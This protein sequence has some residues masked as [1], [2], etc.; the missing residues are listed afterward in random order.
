MGGQGG[1][2][3]AEEG[4]DCDTRGPEKMQFGLSHMTILVIVGSLRLWARSLPSAQHTVSPLSLTQ[5]S[6][7]HSII[8]PTLQIRKTE[9]QRRAVTYLG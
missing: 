9:A 8:S 7:L 4:Q 2:W 1:G 3:A 6:R 5:L